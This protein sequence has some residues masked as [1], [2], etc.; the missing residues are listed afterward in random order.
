MDHAKVAAIK[1]IK[2]Q[3]TFL[4]RLKEALLKVNNWQA[5][6]QAL[7]EKKTGIDAALF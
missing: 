7:E 2:L 1:G 6:C 3:S 4:D 5:I